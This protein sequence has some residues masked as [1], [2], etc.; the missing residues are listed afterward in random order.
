MAAL[1][2]KLRLYLYAATAFVMAAFLYFWH[3]KPIANIEAAYQEQLQ[4]TKTAKKETVVQKAKLFTE[5]HIEKK[6]A[7]K[8]I[9]YEE[10]NGT[11]DTNIGTHT[12]RL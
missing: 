8:G 9:S 6:E 10:Y 11:I 12:K 5:K 4:A 2:Y 3:Y 7:L 1:I